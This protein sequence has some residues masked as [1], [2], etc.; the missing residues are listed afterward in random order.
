MKAKFT[1]LA[2]VSF[3]NLFVISSVHASH[4]AGGEITYRWMGGNTYHIVFT[5]YR[6]CHG[7]AAPNTLTVNLSSASCAFNINLTAAKVPGTG[8]VVSYCTGIS[9]FCNGGTYPGIQKWEYYVNYTLPAHCTDWVFSFSVVGRNAAI[10]TLQNPTA[11]NLYVEAT[12]NNVADTAHDSPVF[13]SDPF[14]VYCVGY[15]S[16][17]DCS[18]I[19]PCGD[20]INYS[21]IEP[22]SFASTYVPYNSGYSINMPFTSSPPPSLNAATGMISIVPTAVEVGVYVVHINQYQNG[23]LIGS[24]MRD[25]VIYTQACASSPI[26]LPQISGI[27]GTNQYSAIFPANHT[28]CFNLFSSDSDSTQ[29]TH[30]SLGASL[31]GD[32]LILDTM[33]HQSGIFCWTPLITD[34][35]AC[36]HCFSVRVNDDF[37]PPGIRSYKYCITVVDSGFILHTNVIDSKFY[38]TVSPNPFSKSAMVTLHG[39][40]PLLQRQFILFDALGR[41]MMNSPM[42]KNEMIIDGTLLPSGIYFYSIREDNTTMATGKIVITQ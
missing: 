38:V 4:A 22:R 10:T 27:N 42:D 9:T 30:L 20:S 8:L 23:V 32:T 40:P 7:I 14:L 12:M 26:Y 36:P 39:S 41:M 35:G 1:F 24:I 15:N 17:I 33:P 25:M 2:L 19:K 37:C 31:P 16:I 34:T 18:V 21:F 3:L 29:T 5:L 11:F 28:S 6:D 13:L